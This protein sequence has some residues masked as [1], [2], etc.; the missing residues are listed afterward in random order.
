MN[1][2][3]GKVTLVSVS[4]SG[5]D[6]EIVLWIRMKLD[7]CGPVDFIEKNHGR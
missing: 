7:D 2:V 6:N 3:T 1:K 4:L 5:G